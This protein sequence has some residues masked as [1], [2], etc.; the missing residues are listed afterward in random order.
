MEKTDGKRLSKALA[1]AG[2]ASRRACE[3][4]ITAG[5]V[6]VNGQVVRIPQTL[7]DWDR[8]KIMVNGKQVSQEEEKVYFL[9]HKPVGY[10][11]TNVRQKGGAKV[12]I[13]LLKHLPHRLFTVGRLDQETSGLIVVTNDGQFANRIIH[14]SHNVSK[15]YL[16][17]TSQEITDEHLKV[18]SSGMMIEGAHVKPI[19]VR[20]VRRG[21]LKVTVGEGKKHEVRLLLAHAGLTV[22]ELCRIRLGPLT[23]ST[24]PLGEYRPLSTKEVEAFSK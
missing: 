12:V 17:K 1:A 18:I 10:L 21:T 3:E 20:K 7:V 16:V 13:D 8:D 4:L 11:C 2:I 15:E 23:L 5:R 9:V 22:R 24:L 14:P 19:A 6:K